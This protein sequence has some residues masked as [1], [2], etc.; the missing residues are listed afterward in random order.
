M[1]EFSVFIFLQGMAPGN[2]SL[3]GRF[4]EGL[5]NFMEN[6]NE[7]NENKIIPGDFNCTMDKME[8]DGRNKT[9]YG[10]CFNYALSKL[11]VDNRLE[12]LWRRENPDSFELTRYDRSSDTRSRLGRVYTDIK[13]ASNTKIHYIMVSFPDHYNAIFI[14]RLLSKTNSGKDSWYFANS[15]LGKPNSP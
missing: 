5:Q 6:K 4:F 8:S 11:I 10:C 14:D 12:H 2:S 1:T 13:A 3:G 9:L 15:L 7:G